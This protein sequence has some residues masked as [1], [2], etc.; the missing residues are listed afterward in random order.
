MGFA[1]NYES[2]SPPPPRHYHNMQASTDNNKICTGTANWVL[3]RR[4]DPL[5]YFAHE[6]SREMEKN[7]VPDPNP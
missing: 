7:S 3:D 1:M 4:I 2:T 5:W 6:A